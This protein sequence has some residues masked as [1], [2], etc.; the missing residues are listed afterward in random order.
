MERR[1]FLKL[2][3]A[4]L[5][6]GALSGGARLSHAASKT[7]VKIGYLPL[8]D[9]LTII[10]HGQ[11][12]Y[13]NLIL[14]PVKFSGW[15]ELS[16]ALRSGAIQG[17]FALTPI[18]LALR[19]KGTAIK[20]VQAAHRNGSVLTA[21]SSPDISKV[22]DLRGKTIA[23]PNRF[24]THNILIHKLLNDRGINPDKDV[25][26]IE[27]APPEMVNAL[28]TGRIDAFLVAEPFGAQAEVQKVGKVLAYSKDI[29]KNHICCALNL[30]ESIIQQNPEAVDELVGNFVR[31]ANFIEVNPQE[32]ATLST[33]YL[34]QKPDVVRFVLENPKD[35]VSF[36]NLTPTANELGVTQDYLIQFGISKERVDIAS[37]LDDRFVK[38]AY[39][40]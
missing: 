19:Q 9:H 18:G 8:T 16:E 17:G 13:K 26:L 20:A 12:E 6:V 21:K 30:Q 27:L 33:R 3:G 39:K 40:A 36:G 2:G 24:S 25:R 11:Y 35:R 23:I 37:Y 4:A 15:P 29:W 38:K 28:S 22:E 34:G 1:N 31:A 5:T 32:A 10:A 7:V 14:E